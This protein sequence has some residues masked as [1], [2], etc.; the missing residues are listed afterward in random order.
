MNTSFWALGWRTLWRDLRSGELRLLMVAVTL[1]V[2]ALTAVGFFSDRLQAGLQRDARQLLGGDAVVVSDNPPAAPWVEQADRLK[3]R[4]VLTLTFPTMGR[5]DDA[6]GGATRLVALK[7]VGDGYPLRGQLRLARDAADREGQPTSGI[8]ERGTVWVDAALLE[9]LALKSGDALLLGDAR[10]RIAELIALEPDRGTGFMTFAPRV[11]LNA[12]DLSATGLVQP[13]SRITYRLAVAGDEPAVR[14]YLTWAEAEVKK[15]EVHGVRL[16]SLGSG[17]PEMTRTLDR[18]EKFLSLVALLAALLSAVAVALAARGFA[19]RHLDDCAMLRVLGL[20]QRAIAGAYT[21]EFVLVGLAASAA[22]VLIGYAVHHV[23]VA[24]LAGLVD[25]A[26]PPPSVWPVLFGIGIG[27]TLLVAFGLPPVLQLAQVP[28]L[29]VLRRDVGALKPA[30]LAVLGLGVAGFA[31]LLLA[32]SSDLT[33]GLIAVGGFAGA[34][35]VFALLSWVAVKGLRR[36]V[37][38]QTAPRWLVLATRQMSAR[39]AYAVVQISS[40][41]V[42]LLALVLLVLLRTDLISSWRAATPADAPNRFVIN[43]MPDQG[44]A[45]RATLKDAGVTKMDW[46]PMFRG[47]LVAINGKPVN[48][49]DFSDDRAQRLVD[50]EFNL[51]HAAERPPHNEISAGR[52]QPNEAGAVSVEQGL[53]ETLGLKLGDRMTFDIAGTPAEGKITSLRKV[54]WASMHANFFVMFPLAEMPDMPI[55]YI[56][57]YRA[58]EIWPPRASA[59]RESLPPEGARATLGRP[60]GGAAG[61]DNALVRQFPNITNVDMSAT[62]AQVQRVLDQVIRAVEFLFGF[63]LM[64]GLI[65]LFAAVSAT[66]EERAREFAIMRAVGASSRLLG[67]VQRAE[68]VGVGLLAGFLASAVAVGV[69]WAMARYAFEFNW[70]A[71]PWVPLAGSAVGAVLALVAGWW[72]LR[73]VLRRPVVETLRRAAAE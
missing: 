24:L 2:A 39:P 34:A 63:T 69:G 50:R 58:P 30:S 11:M 16:E 23:F 22:G 19:A 18:A 8:P 44:E 38:E 17:R 43:V 64:A 56:A 62:L 12:A 15:P 32:V 36:A 48:P 5:A 28:P 72:G 46:Y 13:A 47:R 41:A 20:P 67:D 26:L 49:T 70:T 9:A 31:A 14:Q 37:N 6:Q 27:L 66:R 7:A 40:L 60:G 53:A 73:D 21:V 4:H 35:A 1:A 59:S 52:W 68:L 10:F 29:R 3:L 54:D 42:G 61:F 33:L 57:A 51:S 25:A 65:V 55:T 45:F 71:S